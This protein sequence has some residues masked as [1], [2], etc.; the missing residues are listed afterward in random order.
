VK[1]RGSEVPTLVHSTALIYF[2]TKNIHQ[3]PRPVGTKLAQP[4]EPGVLSFK[5]FR[6]RNFTFTK[7]LILKAFSLCQ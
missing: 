5:P 4:K 6:P 7:R 1:R 2:K 3:K